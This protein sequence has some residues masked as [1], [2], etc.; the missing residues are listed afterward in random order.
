MTHYSFQTW[1]RIF[2]EVYGFCL[3]LKTM[4][5]I[6]VKISVKA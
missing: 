6:L 3:F 2:A 4:V 5:K 1:D